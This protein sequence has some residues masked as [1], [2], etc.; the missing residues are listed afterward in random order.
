MKKRSIEE[1]INAGKE[2]WKTGKLFPPLLL[3][4][5]VISMIAMMFYFDQP[6]EY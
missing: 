3:F 2:K 4:F 1:I 6:I 5:V